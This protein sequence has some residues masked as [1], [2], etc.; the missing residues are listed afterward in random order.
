[1]RIKDFRWAKDKGQRKYHAV[2]DIDDFYKDSTSQ[3]GIIMARDGRV[4]K[5]VGPDYRCKKCE[6]AV[7]GA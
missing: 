6:K 7:R 4:W 1:M 3:C 2:L 5:Y